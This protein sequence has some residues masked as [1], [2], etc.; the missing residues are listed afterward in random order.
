MKFL[1]LKSELKDFTIFSLNEIRNIEVD[2]K[3][4]TIFS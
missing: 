2:P 1:E 3:S 4:R